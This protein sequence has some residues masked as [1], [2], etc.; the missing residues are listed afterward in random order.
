M[1]SA[2][3]WFYGIKDGNLFVF[4]TATDE[5]ELD[6]L[7]PVEEQLE[8]LVLQVGRR[9]VIVRQQNTNRNCVPVFSPPAKRKARPSPARR[10]ERD[11]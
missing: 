11:L 10:A 6:C 3:V 2:N 1:D 5:G 4:E 9:D 7:R 8:G